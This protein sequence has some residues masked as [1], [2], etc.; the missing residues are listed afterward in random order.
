MPSSVVNLSSTPRTWVLYALLLGALTWA[1]FGNLRFHLLETHDFETFRDNANVSAD[2][3]Y[4]FSAE[5]EQ[6]SGRL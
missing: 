2:F 6:A 5:K 1:C 3:A 4:F